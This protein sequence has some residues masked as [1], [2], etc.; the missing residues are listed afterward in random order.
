[1]DT[2]AILRPTIPAR[3][4]RPAPVEVRQAVNTELAPARRVTAAAVTAPA[5]HARGELE[6][7]Q[8]LSL[9]AQINQVIHQVADKE[10]RLRRRP[11]K[12]ALLR[13]RAYVHALANDENPS[14][15]S[16]QTDLTA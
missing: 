8:R 16:H 15:T 9:A 5:T 11:E 12:E 6:L 10:F 3:H 1:M 14:E 7:P 4:E 13:A 2:T